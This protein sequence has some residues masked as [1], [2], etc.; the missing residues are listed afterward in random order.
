MHCFV[1]IFASNTSQAFNLLHT[2]FTPYFVFARTGL[3]RW[4]PYG[5]IAGNQIRNVHFAIHNGSGVL[6]QL[7]R[8]YVA[9]RHVSDNDS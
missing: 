9:L 2:L 5:I 6:L 7:L 4:H 1:T 8:K 3:Q